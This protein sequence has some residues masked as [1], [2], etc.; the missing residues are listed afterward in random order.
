MQYSLLIMFTDLRQ[1]MLTLQLIRI[2][3][4]LW[5]NEGLDLRYVLLV[6]IYQVMEC[7]LCKKFQ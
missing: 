7:A 3:D 4:T 5:K 2:M 6:S 1:D